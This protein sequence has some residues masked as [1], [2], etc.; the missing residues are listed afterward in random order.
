MRHQPEFNMIGRGRS[1]QLRMPRRNI[2]VVRAMDQQHRNFRV[3]HC[4]QRVGLKQIDILVDPHKHSE[5][6]TV[7]SL[8]YT[9]KIPSLGLAGLVHATMRRD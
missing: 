2:S 1:D 4:F 8:W 6:G 7:V 9:E 3:R 5:N